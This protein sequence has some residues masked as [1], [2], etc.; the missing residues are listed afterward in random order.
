MQSQSVQNWTGCSETISL[1]RIV[2][3]EER[4][5]E[6]VLSEESP[7]RVGLPTS[8]Q[9]V[10]RKPDTAGD[11]S[12]VSVEELR[13]ASPSLA[14]VHSRDYSV[15]EVTSRIRMSPDLSFR[16][17]SARA[18][19][20]TAIPTAD[21]EVDTL[22]VSPEAPTE[23]KYRIWIQPMEESPRHQLQCAPDRPCP[24]VVLPG[25]EALAMALEHSQPCAEVHR[26]PVD[27]FSVRGLTARA[28]TSLQSVVTLAAA[29]LEHLLYPSSRRLPN[30]ALL[31][32]G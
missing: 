24:P 23:I 12:I 27:G 7:L 25:L 17:R 31:T 29:E 32:D 9:A 1:A 13:P 21:D 5:Q 10:H 8:E 11:L 2:P 22:R 15:A 4:V 20:S 14:S 16:G 30:P 6:P 26:P 19:W 28:G 18:L 3:L